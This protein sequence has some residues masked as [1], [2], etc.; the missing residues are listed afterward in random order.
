MKYA[1]FILASCVALAV[2][3][4]ASTGNETLRDQTEKSVQGKI[5]AGRTTKEQVRATFGSP[6]STSFTDGGLEI[7]NYEFTNVSNDAVDYVPV[8]NLFGA[9]ASGRKKSLVILFSKSDVVERFSMSDS[10]VT[11]KTGV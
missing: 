9:T 8:V 4:C 10:P 7:W 1:P 3:G 6:L 11:V 2:A 5:F